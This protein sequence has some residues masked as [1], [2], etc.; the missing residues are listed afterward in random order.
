MLMNLGGVL[1]ANGRSAEALAPLEEA[2]D[3]MMVQVGPHHSWTDVY[4]GWLGSAVSLTG[5][6]DAAAQL[7]TWS[8]E[9][10]SSYAELGQ[11]RQVLGML[12]RLVEVMEGQGLNNQAARYR[13]LIDRAAPDP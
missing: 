4:R 3:V 2:L 11:D 13:A 10:L 8:M 7:F 6:Q 9:G 12:G 1:L 5:R